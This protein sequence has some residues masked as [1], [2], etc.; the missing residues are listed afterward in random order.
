VEK[1]KLSVLGGTFDILHQ[2]HREFIK[3]ALNRSQKIII[4]LTN[5]E[6]VKKNKPQT[7]NRFEERKNQLQDFLDQLKE[8]KNVKVIP[9]NDIYGITLDTKYPL[10]AI[11][12]TDETYKGAEK[13]NAKRLKLGLI[14]LDI[15]VFNKVKNNLSSTSIKKGKMNRAGREYIKKK[16]LEKLLLPDEKRNNL[17]KPFGEGITDFSGWLK[18]NSLNNKLLIT[19]GDETTKKF[20]DLGVIPS[21]SIVDLHIRRQKRHETLSEFGFEKDRKIY[22]AKNEAGTLDPSLFQ[23]LKM[24]FTSGEKSVILVKGEDDLAVIPVILFAPLGTLVF[25]GQPDEGVV[26]LVVSEKLKEEMY[27]LVSDFTIST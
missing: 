6:Y 18:N 10:E 11:F 12:V 1:Y 15:E 21:L 9:I 22:I 20:L 17:K 7:I 27:V 24:H 16:W 13:I 19:V 8:N 26:M 23:V 4:G 5:D 14:K 25:Y 3:Y 2:G